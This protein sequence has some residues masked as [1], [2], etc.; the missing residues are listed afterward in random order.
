MEN[1]SIEGKPERKIDAGKPG[2]VAKIIKNS[3]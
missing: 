2:A 3:Y 1:I